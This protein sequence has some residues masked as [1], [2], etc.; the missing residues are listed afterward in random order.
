[1]YVRDQ[2]SLGTLKELERKEKD[3]TPRH[4]QQHLSGLRGEFSIVV[5]RSRIEPLRASLVSLGPAQ[6]VRLGLQKAVQR[7]LDR[8]PDHLLYVLTHLPS[9]I[10]ITSE[11]FMPSVK[12]LTIV[13]AVPCYWCL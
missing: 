6:L 7:L 5:A 8:T 11:N 9:S 13:M 10:L 4:L 2:A 3:A 1:M 12:S